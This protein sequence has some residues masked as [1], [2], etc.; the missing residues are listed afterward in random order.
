M[1]NWIVSNLGILNL[2]VLTATLITVICY[3]QAAFEQAEGAQKPFLC[4]LTTGTM[5]GCDPEMYNVESE[6][7]A[8]RIMVVNRGKGPALNVRYR[9]KGLGEPTDSLVFTVPHIGQGAR[10]PSDA[11]SMKMAQANRI[12]FAAIYD[13]LT[14][15]L[16]ETREIADREKTQ[17]LLS[18]TEFSF[19]RIPRRER[20]DVRS[21]FS[22]RKPEFGFPA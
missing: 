20:S 14:G 19:R 16:Y 4:L 11:T 3:T 18:V 22:L 8:S 9:V 17:R 5:H 15:Q 10:H 12:V 6:Y 2:L 21:E 13:S 7:L 1:W